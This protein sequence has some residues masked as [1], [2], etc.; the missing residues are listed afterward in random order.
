MVEMTS[1]PGAATST[2]EL[3]CENLALRFR[4]STAATDMTAGHEAG[5]S[6]WLVPALPVDGHTGCVVTVP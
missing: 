4:M 2:S 5:K 6:S 1:T 3:N